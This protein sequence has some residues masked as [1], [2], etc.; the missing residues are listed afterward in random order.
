MLKNIKLILLDLDGVIIDSKLN[1]KKSWDKVRKETKLQV[2]FEE[3]FKHIGRPFRKILL[4]LK[5]KKNLN[6]IENIYTKESLKNINN[7][8]LY[9]NIK[10]TLNLLKIKKYKIGV[11]T[12]KEKK[13]TK[14]ILKK[15]NLK[16]KHV[17]SPEKK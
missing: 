14:I 9:P 1:M 15:F 11:V 8:K 17:V 2:K 12:S 10:K 3:Y 7:I 4:K 5:I 13:R 6:M 16:F